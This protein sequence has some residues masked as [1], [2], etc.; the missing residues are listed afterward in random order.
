M[1]T[2]DL[3]TGPLAQAIGW[4]LLH[5]L[6]QATIVAALLAALLAIVPRSQARFRYAASIGAL[7]LLF[8]LFLATVAQSFDPAASPI[9]LGS[10]GTQE[11]VRDL[12]LSRV[13]VVIAATAASA[14][15]DRALDAVVSAR[16]SI[17]TLVAFWFAGVVLLSSRLGISWLRARRMMKSD[18]VTA[19][20][21]WQQACA[22]IASAMGLRRAVRLLE[23]AAI[24][25]PAVI[26]ALRPVI[27]L[28][29]STLS[30][31]SP[32]QIEMV[33]AHELAHIRRHDFLVNLLQAFAETLMFHHPAVWWI[34]HT[35]RVEREHCCDDLALAVSGD[36]VQYARALARLEELRSAEFAIALAANGGSLIERIRRIAG[37]RA[38]STSL[39]SRWI[40]AVAMLSV[41]AIAV[42]VPSFPALA[43]KQGEATPAA[44]TIDVAADAAGRE[45]ADVQRRGHDRVIADASSGRDESSSADAHEHEVEGEDEESAVVAS[46]YSY[47]YDGV[48]DHDFD[49][50]FD[51]DFD[52]DVD[53]VIAIAPVPPA[54]APAPV[55]AVAPAPRGPRPPRVPMVPSGVAP[56]APPAPPIALADAGVWHEATDGDE[57]GETPRDPSGKLSVDEL[58]ALR[59]HGVRPE[60]VVATRALFPSATLRDVV[61]M[62]AVGVTPA[63]VSEL[64]SAGIEAPRVRDVVGLRALGVTGDYIRTMRAAGLNVNARDAGNLKALEVTPEYVRELRAAGIDVSTSRD[65]SSLKALEV[66]GSYIRDLRAA[67]VNVRT[68]RDASSLKAVGVTPDLIRR[69]AAAGYTNLSVK[70]LTSLAAAGIDERFIRE[71]EQYRSRP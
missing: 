23:S 64:R 50:D 9:A 25:V 17:P 14:W 18:A 42:A 46:S 19:S 54:P 37:S 1:S 48:A 11:V 16:Q 29:A 36:R 56:P 41:I 65:A 59:V 63:Y 27:L 13:P 5:L 20:P 45:D 22:R 60:D 67:G 69:L 52:P 30:G 38:E 61:S 66:T 62:R 34:S 28:P 55:P 57:S 39:T 7:A 53:P 8:A 47:S 26:G 40:A 31:L 49:F 24:Q 15:R 4:A 70:D 33:L 43:Q 3:L 71:M 44:S 2:I 21:E 32:Q 51:F 10:A 68:S 35:V 6:W 58:I 12:P